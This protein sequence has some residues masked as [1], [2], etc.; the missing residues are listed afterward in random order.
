M[1]DQTVPTAPAPEARGPHLPDAITSMGMYFWVFVL[2]AVA[3]LIW[4]IRMSPLAN[5]ADL[6]ALFTYVAGITPSIVAILF[7]AAVLLRHPEATTRARTLVVGLVLFAAVEGLRVL[8]LPLQPIFERLTPGS[9]ETPFL[10]PLALI[11]N[12]AIGL[13]ASFA[14]A[15]IGVGLARSRRYEDASGVQLLGALMVTA[16]SLVAV[17][18][19]LSVNQLPLDEITMTPTVVV[20]LAS[21]VI[22][23]VLFAAS[24]AYLATVTIRGSR[25]GELPEPAWRFAATGSGL[26]IAAYAIRSLLVIPGSPG[27]DTQ[28][29]FTALASWLSIAVAVGYLALLVGFL[30]GL[31]SLAETDDE[32]DEDNEGAE[33]ADDESVGAG[34]PWP[35]TGTEPV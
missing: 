1:T 32:D 30:R 25:A 12:G 8:I 21:T 14:V 29:L 7:P 15:N 9:A 6:G 26:I 16:V 33:E 11:Y 23:S 2:L 18:G 20:Y 24:W 31:P 4:F 10:V 3:R 19:V 35:L 22:L 27:P 17:G 28:P 5:P 34:D 13:L